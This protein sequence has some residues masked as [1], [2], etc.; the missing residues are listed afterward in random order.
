MPA[1]RIGRGGPGEERVFSTTFL[2]LMQP[3][4]Q[5]ARGINPDISGQV[6]EK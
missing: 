5:P 2:V 1:D 3:R 4:T 6:V